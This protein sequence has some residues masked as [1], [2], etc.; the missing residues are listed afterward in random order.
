MCDAAVDLL[1][2]GGPGSLE[3]RTAA[4][5]LVATLPLPSPAFGNAVNGVAT[6]EPITGQNATASGVVTKYNLKNNGG[7][8][9]F[10]GAVSETG[11]GGELILTSTNITSGDPINVV[12]LT[13]T[14]PAG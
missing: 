11:G 2:S 9:L 8:V 13:I 6:A 14:V 3:L 12:S 1:D 4:D 7:T 10:S 5:A